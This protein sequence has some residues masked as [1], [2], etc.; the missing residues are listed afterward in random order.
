MH[1]SS[2]RAEADRAADLAAEHGVGWE[3]S[4]AGGHGCIASGQ[5]EVAVE[6]L[7]E[8]H[9]CAVGGAQGQDVDVHLRGAG[10]GETVDVGGDHV[11]GVAGHSDGPGVGV[12]QSLVI[13]LQHQHVSM[14]ATHAHEK[15][16]DACR[17]GRCR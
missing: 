2:M 6:A 8:E 14:A 10:E 11:D 9:S 13:K 5:P 1:A 12:H 15:Q 3:V 7:G 16:C 17:C 4:H